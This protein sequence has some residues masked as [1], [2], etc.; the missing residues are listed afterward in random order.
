[1]D[2]SFKLAINIRSDSDRPTSKARRNFWFSLLNDVRR[3]TKKQDNVSL[4][5]KISNEL[6]K[7]LRPE[8]P[9]QL[10]QIHL[11]GSRILGIAGDD[12]D[13]DIYVDIGNCSGVYSDKPTKKVLE[14]QMVIAQAIRKDPS[15]WAFLKNCEG[16]CPLVV[17]R[18][19]NSNIQCDISFS[20]SMTC[21]QNKLVNY[22]FE[23]QP[24]ARYM[25]VYLRGWAERQQIHSA[26]RSHLLV[27]MV[28]FILQVRRHLPTIYMLQ[29]GLKP[30]VGPWITKFCNFK[31][32]EL[33]IEQVPVNG[34]QARK[35]LADF[36]SFYSTFN[37]SKFVVCPYLGK[38]VL[39]SNLKYMM[40]Q[41]Y[42]Q[43]GNGRR[44]QNKQVAIQDL[45]HL[46]HNK[47]ASINKSMLDCFVEKCCLESQGFFKT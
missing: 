24:I 1:M 31:L 11:F 29:N 28:I 16:R 38:K 13:L 23:L 2:R 17:V 25:V 4:N 40:P 42:R 5:Q 21:G 44:F 45:V 30:D 43:F 10:I 37:F 46:N 8:F 32:F 34:Y 12:S 47:G 18:H 27:L 15:K 6:K 3:A 33:N 36:F 7:T 35:K 26:F 41:R 9:S 19:K 22:I 20:N 39:R 14:Q